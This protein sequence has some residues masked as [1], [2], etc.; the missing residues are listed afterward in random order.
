MTG[1]HGETFGMHQAGEKFKVTELQPGGEKM[2]PKPVYKI[3]ENAMVMKIVYGRRVC[4]RCVVDVPTQARD[5]GFPRVLVFEVDT[6]KSMF[7]KQSM[8]NDSLVY[9]GKIAHVSKIKF[10]V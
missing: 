2:L 8:V 10:R 4:H 5:M 7:W 9:M 6:G 1:A 3:P